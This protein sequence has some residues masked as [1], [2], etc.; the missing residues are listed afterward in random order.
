MTWIGHMSTLVRLDDKVILLDPWFTDYASPLPPFGPHRKMPP[1]LSL[2][3]VPPIDIV[4]VSHNHYEHFDIPTLESLPN[5]EKKLPWLC[6]LGWLPMWSIF[7]SR[8]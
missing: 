5:Q 3:Q 6:L 4:V 1:G 8:K 2:E 7:H